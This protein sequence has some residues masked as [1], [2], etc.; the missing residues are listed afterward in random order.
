MNW[1]PNGQEDAS[2]SPAKVQF[3]SRLDTYHKNSRQQKF[4]HCLLKLDL[5]FPF[6]TWGK[7]GEYHTGE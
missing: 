2:K 3:L 1:I 5:N 7:I 6:D 4:G